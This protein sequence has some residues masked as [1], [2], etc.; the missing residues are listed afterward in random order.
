MK[1]FTVKVLITLSKLNNSAKILLVL[2]TVCLIQTICVMLFNLEGSSP[3][4]VT[5]RSAMSSIFGYF[6]GHQCKNHQFS[7]KGRVTRLESTSSRRN[8]IP[9]QSTKTAAITRNTA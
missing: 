6:F 2:A 5:I 9:A 8:T 7:A 3:S 4:E 1:K